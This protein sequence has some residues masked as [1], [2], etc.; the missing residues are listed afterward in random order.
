MAF[1]IEA[2][3]PEV[4]CAS[5]PA[6]SAYQDELVRR[7]ASRAYE[8]TREF[9]ERLERAGVSIDDVRTA[10][11]LTRVPVLSK[12]D[13]PDLQAS[14][15]PFGGLL[16]G[17]VRE[18]KR[19]FVSPG[20]ILA[21]QGRGPDFWGWAPALW[22]CGFREGDCVYNTFSYHLTPAGAMM[23]EGLAVL[24]CTVVPGGVGNTDAQVELLSLSSSIGYLGTPQFL[25]TLLERA[26]DNAVDVVIERAFVSGAPL[27]ASLREDLASEFG[28]TVR[29]G[30]GTADVGA[31]AFECE[32][33]NG[34]HVAPGRVVEVLEDT[35]EVVVT[36]DNETYPLV[37]FGTGDVSSLE[38][39]PC[40]CGRT[41][42]RLMGFQGRVGEGVK[43]R[44]MFVH[45]RQIVRALGTVFEVIP[46][47][48]AVVTHDGRRD[49]L[50][51]RVEDRT[52]PAELGACLRD[53][54]KLRVDVELVPAG[55]I[56]SDAPRIRDDRTWD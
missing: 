9:P 49:V 51:V 10:S 38:H 32:H 23:E 24:G 56:A 13:L 45:P 18:L 12:E 42:P 5:A 27:P 25:W 47:F 20:P 28:V 11:D 15:P 31:I 19:I 50:V 34:W 55:T 4:E 30:Y 8:R 1:V 6:W 26:R 39:E 37:R 46:P 35:G 43:V 33:V 36:V 40:A 41:T 22:A 48:Q 44:G 53:E 52:D 3:R 2:Y 16:A 29:Q 21:P 54:L 14:S 7:T 17:D